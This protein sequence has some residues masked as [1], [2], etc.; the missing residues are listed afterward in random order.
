V[1]SA[2]APPGY[3]PQRRHKARARKRGQDKLACWRTGRAVDEARSLLDFM[4]RSRCTVDEIVNWIC[5]DDR[6]YRE[7][8]A[9][10]A[11]KPSLAGNLDNM[12]AFRDR[13][14]NI[15][16]FLVEGHEA[17]RRQARC[18]ESTSGK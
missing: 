6:Q 12:M 11:D 17:E 10:A 1:A 5:V 16:L 14:L 13:V 15:F 4:L 3:A 9:W 18:L 7:L 2:L 8:C